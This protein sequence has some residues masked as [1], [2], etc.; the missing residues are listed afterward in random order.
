MTLRGLARSAASWA[1]TLGPGLI[2]GAADDDPSGI[3]TYSIAGASAGYSMLWVALITTPMMAVLNGV[4]AR[5]GVVT[6]GGLMRA[7]VRS[8]ARPFVLALAVTIAVANTFNIGADVAGMGAAAGLVV[9]LPQWAWIPLFTAVIIVVEVFYSYREFARIVKWLCLALLAYVVTAFV[10]HPPW[11]LVIASTLIPRISWNSAWLTTLMG[12]LGTTITPYL[13]FW[14]CSMEVEETE[15]RTARRRSPRTGVKPSD[16]RAVHDDVNTGAIYS[17]VIM[18]FIIVTSAASLGAHGIT[19]IGTAE[20]AARALRPLAGNFAALLF[21]LGI[22]GTGLL[23][24]PVLAG[25]SAY[26]I[27]ELYGMPEGLNQKPLRARGFYGII[28]V[29]MIAGMIMALLRVDPIRALFWSAVLNGVAVVPLLY[30]IIR[31]ARDPRI[32]GQWTSSRLAMGWMWLTFVLMCA[33]VIAMAVSWLPM[34][35]IR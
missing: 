25:S 17:N 27:A 16:I 24:V 10:V 4:C 2:T 12:V 20:D 1:G 13:F 3:S 33:A 14:Q 32:L 15:D 22:V 28:V 23:A 29:G 6:G 5:I 26:M 18:F 9:G 21:S 31:I 34:G 8:M 19:N 35:I 30:A 11:L 7:L